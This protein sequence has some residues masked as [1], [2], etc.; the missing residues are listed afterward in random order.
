MSNAAQSTQ[1]ALS[2]TLIEAPTSKTDENDAPQQR[3]AGLPKR[4]RDVLD[5]ARG[6]AD[7]HRLEE[8]TNASGANARPLRGISDGGEARVEENFDEAAAGTGPANKR[9]C[10]GD[11]LSA[12]PV[13]EPAQRAAAGGTATTAELSS[14]P[15]A[16]AL[17][18]S[19]SVAL[20]ETFLASPTDA[21]AAALLAVATVP[22]VEDTDG[23]RD[24]SALTQIVSAKAD[25]KLGREELTDILKGSDL[26]DASQ[27]LSKGNPELAKRFFTDSTL[28]EKKLKKYQQKKGG[29]PAL[30]F[31]DWQ[32]AVIIRLLEM[33]AS[34]AAAFVNESSTADANAKWDA[35]EA[36]AEASRAALVVCKPDDYKIKVLK[37]LEDSAV[38]LE[39][40][41]RP[42]YKPLF[43]K[44]GGG[45]VLPKWQLDE[46]KR[47]RSASKGAL[48][49][50]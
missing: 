49:R 21:A 30:S 14:E 27:G 41:G 5:A 45:S 3:S 39:E 12:Q 7:A 40:S 25:G 43:A 22:L 13:A 4:S 35:K 46:E 10:L 50:L 18:P 32:R 19:A 48:R 8:I 9:P 33:L 17:A 1:S 28:Y 31:P 2:A 11:G 6:T 47:E 29:A 26:L 34:R 24:Y 37:S 44:R 16:H 42:P 23:L 15:A 20:A 38:A 36:A